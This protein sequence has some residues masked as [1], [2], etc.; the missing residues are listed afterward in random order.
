MPQAIDVCIRGAGIVGRTLALLLARD[1]LR[2]GLV[3][4]PPIPGGATSDVRAYALNAASRHLLEALRAW[5]DEQH[6][7]PVQAMHVHG[8]DGGELQFSATAQGVPALAWIVDVQA[9]QERLADALRYQPLVEWLDAPQAAALTAV[10]PEP[11]HWDAHR[12]ARAAVAAMRPVHDVARASETPA[13]RQRIP[14][15]QTRIARVQHQ[16][17]CHAV[18]PVPAGVFAR[19]EQTQIVGVVV[20]F[21]AHARRIAPTRVIPLLRED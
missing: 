18:W 13:Q 11:V 20:G 7:T 1:R 16:V 6:A 9:L 17:A 2:V 5:P 15:R 19:V 21:G 3:R 4:Q 10:G 14:L 12:H 8:D